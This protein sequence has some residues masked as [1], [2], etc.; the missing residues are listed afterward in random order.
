MFK[1]LARLFGYELIN[2]RR[3]PTLDAHLGQILQRRRID[4]VIDAGANTG[5][6]AAALRKQG[7]R[8][9]ILSFEPV[10]ATFRKLQ[11]NARRDKRWQVFQLALSDRAE[12]LS[13]NTFGASDLSSVLPLNATGEDLYRAAGSGRPETIEADTLDN[14]LRAQASS[15]ASVLLKMDTQGFDLKVFRGAA[16]TLKHVEVV[17]SELSFQPIYVGMPGYREMLSEYEAAGFA[18]SGFH[19]VSRRPDLTAIEMDCVLVRARDARGTDDVSRLPATSA[20]VIP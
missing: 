4:L 13:I 14:V 15:A 3:C 5:Q 11:S 16:E 2:R 20:G 19:P 9:L 12:T 1:S 8:G 6:F 7:Y 18:V 10:A 17:V